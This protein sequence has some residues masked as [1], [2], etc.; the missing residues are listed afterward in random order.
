MSKKLGKAYGAN[1]GFESTDA[2]MLTTMGEY[3]TDLMAYGKISDTDFQVLTDKYEK[4][5]AA[6]KKIIAAKKAGD[7]TA[8]TQAR[9]ELEKSKYTDMEMK[10]VILQPLKPVYTGFKME[11]TTRAA[12]TMYLKTSAF[13]LVPQVVEGLEIENVLLGLED[14]GGDALI[15]VSGVKTGAQGVETIFDKEGNML[16]DLKFK[17]VLSL[18]RSGYKIQQENPYKGAKEVIREATQ[19]QKML[20]ENLFGK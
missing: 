10:D 6:L 15:Y 11:Q 4:Q 12:I 17:N 7:K 13:P 2:Q 8:E 18:D 9:G 3:L 20:F 5:L 14:A 19:G 16:S 1:T